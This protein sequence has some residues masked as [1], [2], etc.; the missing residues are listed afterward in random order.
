MKE[1]NV[2]DGIGGLVM[3]VL[4][5]LA[6]ITI[7][8]VIEKQTEQIEHLS[9]QVETLTCSTDSLEINSY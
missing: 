4:F 7:I 5:A 6:S 9:E 3:V 1:Y 8:V 2:F